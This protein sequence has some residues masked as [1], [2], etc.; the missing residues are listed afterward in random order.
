MRAG[1]GVRYMYV[2]VSK[3]W[4]DL[5]RWCWVEIMEDEMCLRAGGGLRYM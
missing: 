1:G 3:G 4:M 5:G 2:Q